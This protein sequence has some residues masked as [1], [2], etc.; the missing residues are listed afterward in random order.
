LAALALIA[1]ANGAAACE[2]PAS[3]ETVIATCAWR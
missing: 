2:R 3:L 1:F